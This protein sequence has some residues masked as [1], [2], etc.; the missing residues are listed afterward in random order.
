MNI[1]DEKKIDVLLSQL[2]ERY[3]ALHK[4][5]DRS[6]QF[7]LWILGFGLGLAW[8]LIRETSFILSQKILITILLISLGGTTLYFIWSIRQG[9]NTTRQ[10]VIRLEKYLKLDDKNYYG[11][12][13]SVL[14]IKYFSTKTGITGHFKTLNALIIVMSVALMFLTWFHPSKSEVNDASMASK[15]V[16]IQIEDINNK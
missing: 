4:M 14:P 12:S 8:L 9:F 13:E 3:D 5:R 15:Q 2:Q 11:A 6:M 1:Q 16:Q 7:T 10:I